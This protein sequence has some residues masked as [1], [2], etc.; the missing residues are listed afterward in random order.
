MNSLRPE[1]SGAQT[2]RLMRALQQVQLFRRFAQLSPEIW[3]GDGDQGFAALLGALATQLSNTVFGD[4]VVDV[5]LAG[6]D[7]RPRRQGGHNT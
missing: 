1:F 7:M 5:I 6:R 2:T 4:H 3:V